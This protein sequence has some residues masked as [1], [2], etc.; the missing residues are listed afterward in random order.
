M[1]L[2]FLPEKRTASLLMGHNG[3]QKMDL[4]SKTARKYQKEAAKQGCKLLGETDRPSHRLYELPC[5]HSQEITPGNMRIGRFVC[6][7]CVNE[8]LNFEASAQE[9]TL[10]GSGANANYRLYRLP[11]RHEQEVKTGHMRTGN[12]KCRACIDKKLSQEAEA[13]G[14]KLLSSSERGHYRLYALSC[15]HK[16][17]VTVRNMRIGNFHCKTCLEQKLH[18]EAREQR[19]EL[20][21]KGVTYQYRLYK[22][23]CR[24]EQEVQT[25][26]MR[27]GIFECKYCLEKKLA[28]EARDRGCQ[29]LAS[30]HR[31]H[32]RLYKLPCEHT[33]E[34]TMQNMRIG[35]FECKICVSER[36]LQEAKVHKSIVLGPGRNKNFRLYELSCGHKQ[37]VQLIHMR[38]GAFQCQTCEENNRTL[39]SSIYLLHI[40]RKNKE[41]L[42]LGYARSVEL[43]ITQYGLSN[44]VEINIVKNAQVATG[45]LAHA[46]EQKIHGAYKRKKITKQV[47][48]D[49]G[50]LN[51]FNECYPLSMLEKLVMEFEARVIQG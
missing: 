16:Q 2:F 28:K 8:K 39:P 32:Y 51:G 6:R 36:F 38:N 42:K 27:R 3:I 25:G 9:C 29:I 1:I 21:G 31:R 24:H 11:C 45:N 20:L 41:W 22:L 14:C 33:Q 50:M 46:L 13:Q 40:K 17:S 47:A 7:T 49:Y 23:P 5:R 15:E 18:K 10:L 12:F 34:I 35:Q 44:D 37:E 26:H 30:E 4:K 19:C 43:R 48:K